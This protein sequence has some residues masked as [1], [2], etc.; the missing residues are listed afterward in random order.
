MLCPIDEVLLAAKQLGA[1]KAPGPDGF[2]GLFYQKYWEIVKD[3]INRLMLEYFNGSITLNSINKTNVVLVPKVP[4]ATSVNQFRPI[5]LCNNGYKILS[6]ILANRLKGILGDIISPQK[7]AFVP[8]RQIQDNIIV[9]HEAFHYLKLKKHGDVSE[10]G[11]KLDMNK[12]YDRVEWDFVEAT[13]G[14]FGFCDT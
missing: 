2:P 5:S 9:A 4:N 11:L 3:N 6:K 10:L 8:G 12:A 1:L 13:L 7:K 14:Q